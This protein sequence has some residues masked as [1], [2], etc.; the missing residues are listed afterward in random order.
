MY[1]KQN[2]EAMKEKSG[3]RCRN[4]SQEEK[5]KIKRVSKKEKKNQELAQYKK[6]ALKNK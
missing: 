1:Y 2:K 5:D 6:E 3:K 4:L